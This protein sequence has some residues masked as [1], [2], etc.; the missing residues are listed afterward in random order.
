MLQPAKTCGR[1]QNR[2]NLSVPNVLFSDFALPTDPL[3]GITEMKGFGSEVTKGEELRD[4]VDDQI[5]TPSG[6]P[7]MPPGEFTLL[8]VDDL[9]RA[10]D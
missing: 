3:L 9:E 10:L 1:V 5:V 8:G 7:L 2:Y 6:N 4:S